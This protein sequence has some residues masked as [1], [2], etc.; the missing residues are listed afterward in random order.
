MTDPSGVNEMDKA[1][2]TLFEASVRKGIAELDAGL[3]VSG[4]DMDEWAKSLFSEKE[5]PL[6]P[7]RQRLVPD[8]RS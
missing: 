8:I 4:K 7:V 6:P 5:L 3:Y 2:Q 1:E